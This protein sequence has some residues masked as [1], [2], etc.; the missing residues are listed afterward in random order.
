MSVMH[1]QG[2][3]ADS[4]S[5]QY[6]PSHNWFGEGGIWE[7]DELA[8]GPRSN[9]RRKSGTGRRPGRRLFISEPIQARVGW[10][11][12][13]DTYWPR[14]SVFPGQYDILLVMDEVDF[15]ASP[16]EVSGLVAS[17]YDRQACT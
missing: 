16:H 11:Y 5:C 2:E 17:N 1:E 4:V 9:W 12:R 6:A 15:A 7:P 3:P 10:S 13:R 14:S 8:C